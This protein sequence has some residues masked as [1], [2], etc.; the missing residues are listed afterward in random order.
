MRLPICAGMAALGRAA[1]SDWCKEG[2]ARPV[3]IPKPL[4]TWRDTGVPRLACSGR[5]DRLCTL[6]SHARK[7]SARMPLSWA[8]L[9]DLR[10]L[11]GLDDP[12]QMLGGIAEK[13]GHLFEAKQTQVARMGRLNR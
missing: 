11:A 1:A 3:C 10:S 8:E 12:L 7:W 5:L 13:K 6:S 2:R 4:T 9:G